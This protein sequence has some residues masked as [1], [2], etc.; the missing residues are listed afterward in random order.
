MKTPFVILIYLKIFAIVL[1]TLILTACNDYKNKDSYVI[2]V[3]ETIEIY[4]STNS[5]C[6]Y[7][8]ANNQE[9]VHINL[10]EDKTIDPGPKDCQGCNYMAA[11]IFEGVSV[12]TDTVELKVVP[13]SKDC[14]NND[15][16][17]EIYIVEVK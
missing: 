2:E 8:V 11:F 5:C 7:C 17:P 13:A 10:L 9:L 3:G 6:Q 14:Y 4:Y 16:E 15:V 1:V 12:G